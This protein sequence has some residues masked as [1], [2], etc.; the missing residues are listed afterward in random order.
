MPVAQGWSLQSGWRDPMTDPAPVKTPAIVV[1]RDERTVRLGDVGIAPENPRFSEPP[2]DEIPD[3]AATLKA[4]GQLERLTVRP[5][6]GRRERPFMALNGRRR[7]LAFDVLLAAGE[8]DADY[9]VQICVETDPARQAAAALLTNSGLPM[10][11]ADVIRAIGRML[12]SRLTIP[13]MARALGYAEIE[14]RRLAALAALPPV[15]LDALK[16]GR[17]TLKQARSLARLTSRREQV[18]LAEAALSG[19]GFQ[20]WR[21]DERQRRGRVTIHDR[22]CALVSPDQYA[23]AGGRVETDLFGELPTV[24]LDPDILS[25]LWLDRVRALVAPFEA[26]GLLV[27]V[28]VDPD[29]DMPEGLKAL[30]YRREDLDPV[31]REAF[32]AARSRHDAAF[33][34]VRDVD[35][36]TADTDDLF[37]ALIRSRIALDQTGV[38][39]R[40]VTAILAWPHASCGIDL[41][42]YAPL[43]AEADEDPDIDPVDEPS[44]ASGPARRPAYCPPEVTAPVPETVGVSH[45]LHA[46]RTDVATRGLIRALADD[47]GAALAVLIA[48][49][50]SV[51]VAGIHVAPSESIS[52]VTATAL[53]SRTHPAIGTLDGVVRERLEV[54][55]MAWQASGQTILAWVVALPHGEKMGLLAELTAISLDG[56]EMRTDLIRKRMRAEAAEVADLIAADITQYWTPDAAFLKPHARPQLLSMLVDMKAEDVR[57]PSLKKDELVD[58]VAEQSAAHVWAPA[59]LSWSLA[60]EPSAC[61]PEG[62]PPAED[63]DEGAEGPGGDPSEGDCDG[64]GAFVVTAAGEAELA[65]VAA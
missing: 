55:R 11:V 63:A 46:V 62:E 61:D 37:V 42:C 64:A 41:R 23:A 57:A 6:R 12:K 29:A 17:L 38:G 27:H 28:S 10:H 18:E 40:A 32:E 30:G 14:I 3:L 8:I 1:T 52:T 49:L 50:F 13:I 51:L 2:D 19:Y 53:W 58:W 59:S 47:P 54:R 36:T 20:D 33:E 7:L 31:E 5:G 45:A 48:R 25:D 15:A 16:A 39:G 44:V 35:K 65:A 60:R 56:R 9:P 34:A 22:R 26:E 24:L 43:E 4:A 21:I